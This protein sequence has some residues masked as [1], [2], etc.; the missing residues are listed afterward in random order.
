MLLA[1]TRPKSRG[2]I[3][4][5]LKGVL[6]PN[7]KLACFVCYLKIMNTLNNNVC[8]LSRELKNGIYILVVSK[9]SKYCFGQ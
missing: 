2:G 3:G 4:I 7:F 9:Q 1:Y 6:H 5:I 8:K